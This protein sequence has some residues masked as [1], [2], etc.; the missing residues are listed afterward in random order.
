MVVRLPGL[1]EARSSEQP[2]GADSSE[3]K[4]PP[5]W[6]QLPG[7]TRPSVQST[8]TSA[9]ATVKSE[10]Q[11]E[12]VAV[13]ATPRRN[14]GFLPS[15]R[16]DQRTPSLDPELW[17]ERMSMQYLR[18]YWVN[19]RTRETSWTRTGS[20]IKTFENGPPTPPLHST[21]PSPTRLLPRGQP[22]R[23]AVEAADTPFRLLAA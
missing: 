1:G 20:P 10:K 18:S 3:D 19:K 16:K 7:G 22:W 21:K 17:E 14:H 11:P 9:R 2:H 15:P 8:L 23:G 5:C 12:R 4:P 6:W 13:I